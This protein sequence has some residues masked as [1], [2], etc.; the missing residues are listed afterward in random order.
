MPRY[1]KPIF[2]FVV[3]LQLHTLTAQ[4]YAAYQSGNFGGLFHLY[5]NPAGAIGRE[6]KA[7][8]M[9]GGLDLNFNNSFLLLKKEAIS[10]PT[11]PDSWR[12]QTPTVPDNIYKNFLPTGQ[13][14]PYALQFSQRLALP[15]AFYQINRR[16]AVALIGS[17]RQ[18]AN[19]DGVSQNLADLIYKEFDLSLL[20]NNVFVNDQFAITKMAWLEYGL[21]YAVAALN[22]AQHRVYAGATL[23][24]TKG[25]EANY[26]YAS[27]TSFLL[28]TVDNSSYFNSAVSVASSEGGGKSV[29]LAPKFIPQL[30]HAA[31]LQAATDIGFTY[32]YRTSTRADSNALNYKLRFSAAITD[33]GGIRFQKQRNYY[34]LS[35]DVTQDDIFRYMSLNSAKQ[36]QDQLQTDFPSNT[37]PSDFMLLLPTALNVQSDYNFNGRFFLNANLH[38]PLINSIQKLRVHDVAVISVSPR[39]ENYWYEISLP[40]SYNVLSAQ[41]KQYLQPG[42]SVRAG[43]LSIGTTDLSALFRKN[44]AGV[45]FYMMLKYSI[46]KKKT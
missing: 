26:V 32:E 36:V 34:D 18:Y 3:V 8:V 24:F 43:P 39:Y 20:Q 29:Q 33:I 12:N 46:K 1:L 35:I 16:H 44:L 14:A 45:N 25:L 23:K 4:D 21:N 42:L 10:Y 11:L 31:A 28:S 9:L 15:S 17:Y 40:L 38:L 2:C 30:K 6:I 22:T 37:G 7:D 13:S 19:I 27:Q 41:R 5:A